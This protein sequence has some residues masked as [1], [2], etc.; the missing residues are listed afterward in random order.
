ME[1]FFFIS[2]SIM[3][4]SFAGYSNVGWQLFSF[5]N[6]SFHA[7]LAFE[8]SIHK[9]AVILT[10]LPLHEDLVLSFSFQYSFL[11]LYT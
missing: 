10:G 4:D 9:S 11:I 7:F 1:G 2:P 5:R 8:V 3:K 6:T